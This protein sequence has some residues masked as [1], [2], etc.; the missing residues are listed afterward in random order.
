MHV[1][2]QEKKKSQFIFIEERNHIFHVFMALYKRANTDVKCTNKNID[3]NYTYKSTGIK[4]Q[5]ISYPLKDNHQFSHFSPSTF[6]PFATPLK[7][8]LQNN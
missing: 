1:F 4:I 5:I 6:L 2:F 7:K 3:A 8:Y